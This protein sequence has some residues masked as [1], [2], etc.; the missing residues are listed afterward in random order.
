MRQ[1]TWKNV[2]VPAWTTILLS[3]LL[4]CVIW[5]GIAPVTAADRTSRNDAATAESLPSWPQFHG[6]RRDN[7]SQETGLLIQRVAD[8]SPGYKLGLKPGKIRVRIGKEDIMLGGDIILEIQGKPI[9]KDEKQILELRK[10][11]SEHSD[12]KNIE[13]TVLRG[14]KIIK[15]SRSE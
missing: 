8:L 15:L 10:T 14:G 12:L 4:I 3:G 7:I 11:L 6:P 5:F 9:S 2:T 13:F 1:P